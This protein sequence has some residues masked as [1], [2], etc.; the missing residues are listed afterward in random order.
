MWRK[1]IVLPYWAYTY[2]NYSQH[3]LKFVNVQYILFSE[4]HVGIT[5]HH[6]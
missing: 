3:P 2:D 5:P 4:I 6:Q 1:L